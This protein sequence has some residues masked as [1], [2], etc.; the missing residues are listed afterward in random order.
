MIERIRNFFR[1]LV[2]GTGP[3]TLPRAEALRRATAALLVEVMVTDQ[4]L[5]AAEIACIQTLLAGRFR[6][7]DTEV[8]ELLELAQQEVA[9]ATS[10]YQFTAL[11]NAHMSAAEKYELVVSLWEVAYADSLLDKHEEGL[12]RHIAELIHLPH[13]AFVQARNQARD[14]LQGDGSGQRQFPSST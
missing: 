12:I 11:V 3:Q 10:L 8:Q 4:Q 14:S 13:A 5:D 7:T 1:D 6:L 2:L 9:E